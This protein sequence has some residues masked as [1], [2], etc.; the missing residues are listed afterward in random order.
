MEQWEVVSVF[1]WMLL[2]CC[3]CR[4][5]CSGGVPIMTDTPTSPR[6]V[7]RLRLVLLVLDFAFRL[8]SLRC[9]HRDNQLACSDDCGPVFPYFSNLF[10]VSYFVYELLGYFLDAVDA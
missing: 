10:G 1:E 7:Y 9:I 6:G 8:C 3:S 2:R 4:W 5:G